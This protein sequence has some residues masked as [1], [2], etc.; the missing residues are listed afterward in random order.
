MS[1]YDLVVCELCGAAY[2]DAIPSQTVFDRYYEE[3]SK[4][5]RNHFDGAVNPVDAERYR[6]V[7]DMLA[8]HLRERDA[9]AD[10]GCATGALL[11][12]LK[13]RGFGNLF[14]IDPSPACVAAGRKLYGIEMRA[15]TIGRLQEIAERFDTVILGGVL[16]HLCDVD[17]SVDRVTGL[18]K[19]DGRLYIEVPDATRYHEWFSAPYQFLSMEHVNFFSPQSLSNLMF[20]HGL[21]P[22]FVERVTRWLSPT[23]AEPAIS[24][25]F[26]PI[27]PVNPSAAF[28]FDSETGPTLKMY[29][30]TSR[31]L[32]SKINAIIDGLTEAHAP[33]A[34]WGAGTH[35]LRL[36]ETSSLAK[37]NLVAFIDSNSRY[38]GK[39]LHGVPILAPSDWHDR[40][41]TVLISSQVAEREIKTQ[42]LETLKWAN[43]LVCLY[44]GTTAN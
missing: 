30:D 8:P 37:A 11:A 34:V 40:S 19:P 41:A 32:E 21:Q 2:S 38:Q 31:E 10:I 6:N 9:I 33:L 36:L 13:R 14:G 16:E 25:L 44:E 39:T 29:F 28:V 43:P 17:A 20:R 5:E 15:L 1:G 18:L 35:T 27:D 12:E 22:V 4:Y 26:R 24:G 42:I 3:M 7:A 23:S